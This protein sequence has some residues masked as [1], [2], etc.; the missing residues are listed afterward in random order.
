MQ[1]LDL[2]HEGTDWV[3]VARYA[4]PTQAMVILG[5][6]QAAGVPATVADVHTLQM[7]SLLAGAIPARL[8]VPTD[9]VRQAQ[10]VLAAFERGDFA[11][12]EVEVSPTDDLE[13]PK[14]AE[15]DHTL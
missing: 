14:R 11:L 15:D 13:N 3:T 4:D 2:D 8:Q 7:H 10:S 12:P 6:L 5:C 1:T 9:W